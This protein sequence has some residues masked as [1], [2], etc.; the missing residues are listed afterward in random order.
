[1][2]QRVLPRQSANLRA[3]CAALPRDKN[4]LQMLSARH[5]QAAHPTLHIDEE[6]WMSEAKGLRE[7]FVDELKDLYNAE[8]QLVK[9]LPKMAK[10]A[11]SPELKAGFEEHLVQTKGHVE[12]LESIFSKLGENPKGKKCKGMEG[13]IEEG[14]EAIEEYEGAVRDAALIGGAQR[15]EH[16]EMAGYGTV[17]AM[18]TQLG[19]SKHAQLLEQ[20]LEEEKET[21]AKLTTLSEKVNPR[22]AGGEGPSSKE[23]KPRKKA[24]S[25]RAA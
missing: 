22:A 7:L 11:E 4:A 3:D 16:Y 24:A 12:R 17:V 23:G 2:M 6:E 18:A 14:G 9:A 15:V 5:R 25:R 10:A 13:L 1:M 19:E 20:T 8:N 21:D